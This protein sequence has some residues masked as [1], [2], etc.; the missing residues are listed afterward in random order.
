VTIDDAL[1]IDPDIEASRRGPRERP[2]PDV[3]AV[4][5]LGG[6]LGAS[7]RYGIARWL[8]VTSGQFPWATFWTNLSGCF[9]LGFLLVVVVERLPSTR[10]VRPFAATGIVGAYTTMSTFAV[11]SAL[12]VHDGKPTTAVVYVLASLAGGV[13]LTFAGIRIARSVAVREAAA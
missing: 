2:S 3:L 6:M 7:A 1:P 8:P 4:I 11:E 13:A 5:A 12:L 9:V 10:L